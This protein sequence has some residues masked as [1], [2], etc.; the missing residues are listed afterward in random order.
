MGS[1][2]PT[3]QFA[4]VMFC[5]AAA[6]AAAAGAVRL[7]RCWQAWHARRA[8]HDRA[9]LTGGEK[10]EWRALTCRKHRKRSGPEPERAWWW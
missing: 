5:A 8:A 10:R 1:M 7:A 6:V 4:A 9:R 2:D 3:P